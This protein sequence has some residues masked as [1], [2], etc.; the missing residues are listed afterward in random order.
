MIDGTVTDPPD[1]AVELFNNVAMLSYEKTLRRA[2]II[3]A[4]RLP[5]A[6]EINVAR[7]GNEVQF[8]ATLRDLMS[9]DGFHQFIIEGA[10]DRLLTD[11]FLVR[12]FIDF[13]REPWYPEYNRLLIEN[14]ELVRAL[15]ENEQFDEAERAWWKVQG[16]LRMATS[17]EPLE[18]IA[19]IV[20]TD[21]PYSEVVTAD[22]TVANP[23]LA[24]AYRDDQTFPDPDD[25]YDFRVV[26]NNGQI[27]LDDTVQFQETPDFNRYISGG[28]DH[29]M[30][31]AGVLN[32]LSLLAR[33]PS[34]ATNRNRARARWTYY[35]FLGVDIEKS[36]PRTTDPVALA[37]T[38]N[39]TLNNPACTVCHQLHD[40]VAG[41]FQNHAF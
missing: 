36:A 16:V 40:P 2:A 38:N 34:T 30:R 10:N 39:P 25:F 12:P 7:S 13:S 29:E 1:P 24:Q 31:H 23:L 4:G 22:F 8:R 20:E 6:A 37:D 17:R 11:K 5:T 26:Q 35:F 9:G 41:T 28:I 3:L 21:R 15:Y 18:L 32:A 19:H 33:Y 14:M 27:L